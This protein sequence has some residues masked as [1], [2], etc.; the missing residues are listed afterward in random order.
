MINV[1]FFF[2]FPKKLEKNRES[3]HWWN[4]ASDFC[5]HE[6]DLRVE[7]FVKQANKRSDKWIII[8]Q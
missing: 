3:H 1:T 2:F 5:Q 4:R 7:E 8:H 6:R